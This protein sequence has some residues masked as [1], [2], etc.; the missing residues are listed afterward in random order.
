M[1]KSELKA[2]TEDEIQ[3]IGSDAV[4]SAISFVES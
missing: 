3:E 2:M 4:K 1:A